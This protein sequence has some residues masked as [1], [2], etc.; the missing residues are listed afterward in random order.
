M[1]HVTFDERLKQLET[2][3]EINSSLNRELLCKKAQFATKSTSMES[4]CNDL[5]V[6]VREKTEKMSRCTQANDMSSVDLEW[7]NSLELNAKRM[8]EQL[9]AEREAFRINAQSQMNILNMILS[10]LRLKA[11]NDIMKS[12]IYV[13]FR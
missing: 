12:T 4:A 3:L 2:D 6:V 7:R 13:I 1:K 10:Q 8:S 11:M 5:M 9:E